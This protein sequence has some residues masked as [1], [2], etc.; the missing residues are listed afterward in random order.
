MDPGRDRLVDAAGVTISSAFIAPG[1]L[2]WRRRAGCRVDL[3]HHREGQRE[4]WSGCSAPESDHRSGGSAP[5]GGALVAQE[6]K[7][8]LSSRI[9]FWRWL[10]RR[11]RGSGRRYGARPPR[12]G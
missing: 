8:D 11:R 6:H 2:R 1:T 5:F 12:R 10:A 7:P 4:D 3:V 9:W